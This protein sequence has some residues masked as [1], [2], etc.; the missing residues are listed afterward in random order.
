MYLI[1][2]LFQ[3]VC[4][5]YIVVSK[6]AGSQAGF[7]HFSPRSRDQPKAHAVDVPPS[8]TVT[9]SLPCIE[10]CTDK[11]C[12]V[13][14]HRICNRSC[15][16]NWNDGQHPKDGLHWGNVKHL[17]VLLALIHDTGTA[18]QKPLCAKTTKIRI[19]RCI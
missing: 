3:L 14:Q 1:L 16:A 4:L 12:R 13:L 8:T 11:V 6:Q 10:G 19:I 2:L 15:I 17:T 7:L 9:G 18:I 5:I